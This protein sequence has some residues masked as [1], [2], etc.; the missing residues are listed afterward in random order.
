[1]LDDYARKQFPREMYRCDLNRYT[2]YVKSSSE[3]VSNQVDKA[4]SI[5]EIYCPDC[6]HKGS[7]YFWFN[8]NETTGIGCSGCK[9]A[10]ARLFLTETEIYTTSILHPYHDGQIRALIYLYATDFWNDRGKPVR[11]ERCG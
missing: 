8:V 9:L 11:T 1:M 10:L 4:D 5:V 7:S 2:W 6:Y 3:P